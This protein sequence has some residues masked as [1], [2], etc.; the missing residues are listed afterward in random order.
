MRRWP[1]HTYSDVLD[2]T[3]DQILRL[4][5]TQPKT[6]NFDTQADYVRWLRTTS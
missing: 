1:A 4:L 5:N 2:M 6:V 3:P